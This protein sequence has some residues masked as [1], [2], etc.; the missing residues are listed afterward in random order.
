MVVR[1]HYY[2][3]LKPMGYLY[4]NCLRLQ[5]WLLIEILYSWALAQMGLNVIKTGRF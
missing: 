1:K 2:F 4:F 5:P 3:G